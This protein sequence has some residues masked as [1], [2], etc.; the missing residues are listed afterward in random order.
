M[1]FGKWIAAI[2]IIVSGL[3][4]AGFGVY[5]FTQELFNSPDVPLAIKIAL[6]TMAGGI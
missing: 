3:V 1:T 6:P 2:M 4:L 5:F